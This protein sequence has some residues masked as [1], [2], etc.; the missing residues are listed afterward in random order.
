MDHK[1]ALGVDVPSPLIEE[2]QLTSEVG[3]G[4]TVI[5]GH[6]EGASYQTDKPLTGLGRRGKVFCVKSICYMSRDWQGTLVLLI[7][8]F[9]K[10]KYTYFLNILSL[11][12]V[13]KYTKIKNGN[14]V[15]Q[16]SEKAEHD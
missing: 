11:L 4:A 16:N 3:L 15:K 13:H 9:C 8:C 12:N 1:P 14:Q 6:E 5:G 10:Y 7:V 2:G